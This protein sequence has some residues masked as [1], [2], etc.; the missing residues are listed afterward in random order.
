MDF[1]RDV[2]G[3]HPAKDHQ[4]SRSSVTVIME[5]SINPMGRVF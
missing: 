2:P 5:A 1:Q 3:L 4:K